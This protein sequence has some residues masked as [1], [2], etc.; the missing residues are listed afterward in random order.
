V[1]GRPDSGRALFESAP[2]QWPASTP[3]GPTSPSQ[4]ALNQVDDSFDPWAEA[5]PD[6]LAL[7]L[8]PVAVELFEV[9]VD[10]DPEPDEAFA[11]PLV[12]EDALEP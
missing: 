4:G 8:L 12:E 9:E 3:P 1:N 10:A 7:A 11:L 2:T 6:E 5:V